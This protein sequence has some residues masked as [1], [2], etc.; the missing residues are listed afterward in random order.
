M[1]SASEFRAGAR[2]R[3][4]WAATDWNG[5]PRLQRSYGKMPRDRPP[6]RQWTVAGATRNPEGRVDRPGVLAD[7]EPIHP[8]NERL[9]Q[10]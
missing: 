6:P 8:A 5:G 3:A 1:T 4:D 9:H 2:G 10:G 7:L